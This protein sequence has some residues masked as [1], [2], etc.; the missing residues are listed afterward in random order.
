MKT[1]SIAEKTAIYSQNAGQPIAELLPWLFP[2]SPKIVVQKDGSLLASFVFKGLDIDSTSNADINSA[3]RQ[4]LYALDQ[5][6]EQPIMMNWQMRRRETT[7]YPNSKFPDPV[8]QRIDELHCETLM[9][10]KQFVNVPAFSIVMLPPADSTRFLNRLRRASELGDDS[11]W[12]ALK[13]SMTGIGDILQGRSDFPHT[14]SE[15]LIDA[16]K[17]FEKYI[18]QFLA[19]TSALGITQLTGDAFS[20]YLCSCANPTRK[21]SRVAFPDPEYF[22]DTALCADYLNNFSSDELIFEGQE[23]IFSAS[24]SF[25]LIKRKR[26]SLDLFDKLLADRVEF[27]L[28]HVY[29]FLPRKKGMNVVKAMARHHGDRKMSP[30]A[31][32][33]GLLNGGDFSGA[34]I[35][36][37]RV[38]AEAE[39]ENFASQI[40]MSSNGAG[41][42]Y[43]GLVVHAQSASELQNSC[44]R[45]E[46]LL[47]GA[48]L[49]PMRE[50]LHK[51]STWTATIPGSHEEIATWQT[52]QTE[53]FADLLPLR[54]IDEGNRFNKYLSEALKKPCRALMVLPTRFKT[55]YHFTG[56]VGDVGHVL[57]LGPT[58]RGKTTFANLG[59]TNFRKYPSSR[60][61]VFDKN[62]STR[63]AVLL[64][65]GKY[66]DLNPDTQNQGSNR[67]R[68][69]PLSALLKG[70]NL[71]HV[72]YLKGW[73]KLLA[74]MVGYTPTTDDLSSIER[75]LIS[76][77]ELGKS[78]PSML[79]LATLVSKLDM[80]LGLARALVQWTQGHSLGSYFDNDHDDID[81]ESL[82][83]IENGSILENDEVAPPYMSYA[84]YRIATQ[85]RSL[86]GDFS[87]APTFI[88]IP[89]VWYFLKNPIFMT[90]FMEWLVTLRKLGACI[91]MDTQSPDKLVESAIYSAIRD[92][93][94]TI[95]LTPNTRARSE[96]LGSLLRRE[97]M[98][99]E[100]ALT[101]IA[102]GVPKKDFFISQSDEGNFKRI[103][104]SLTPG[105]MVYLRSDKLAQVTLNRCIEQ[106]GDWRSKY[107]DLM[108][109]TPVLDDEDED[110]E[111]S[112]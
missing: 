1:L 97:F 96:S 64:Q 28:T 71:E 32:A 66:I 102:E 16:G 92:N 3:R 55:L 89:E 26:L 79:R 84:F 107:I 73:V 17:Q 18:S 109:N 58:G 98:L 94:P 88:F 80:S 34:K 43:G 15:D 65:G 112:I 41:Y 50:T 11:L 42:Y 61:L 5:L 33:F 105:Q 60:V 67:Y 39:A 75:A 35:N 37:G 82:T 103:S 38:E 72:G 87:I 95:V 6:Q 27:T 108:V 99:S 45:V 106:G 36:E 74:Q 57:I 104:L 23:K 40:E 76:T 19:A 4:V 20:G 13:A 31:W 110:L 51:L 54:T 68:M 69:G 21:I 12:G 48:R 10:N 46:E 59:W 83:A 25:R 86:V 22:W 85:M 56:Y 14:N 100:E 63:P 24:Y 78:D 101:H 93:V 29:K 52:I 53:N 81:L 111:V 7:S 91:W 44:Q 47:S 90:E 9:A 8:S 49:L 30:A 77:A 2:L 62:Y 70:G